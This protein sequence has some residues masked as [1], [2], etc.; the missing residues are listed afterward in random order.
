MEPG[1]ENNLSRGV[2][3]EKQIG[4][5]SGINVNR[6]NKLPYGMSE[7]PRKKLFGGH[8]LKITK[9]PEGQPTTTYKITNN[10][11]DITV[12][13]PPFSELSNEFYFFVYNKNTLDEE[14]QELLKN[15]TKELSTSICIILKK[16]IKKTIE[17]EINSREEIFQKTGD[18]EDRVSYFTTELSCKDQ[19]LYEATKIV[20]KTMDQI[21]KS[22]SKNQFSCPYGPNEIEET[23][24]NAHRGS[25]LF[26]QHFSREID[27]DIDW[28]PTDTVPEDD[29]AK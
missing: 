9:G 24:Q 28:R 15:S 10:W 12:E 4:T 23:R 1:E 25:Y 16:E 6:N 21:V 13:I 26:V 3:R 14:G 11:L 22:A 17:E 18:K 8:Q 20:A 2:A 27:N 19:S 7:Y 29:Y 5:K